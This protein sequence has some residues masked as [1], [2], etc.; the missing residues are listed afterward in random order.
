[1]E[2]VTINFEAGPAETYATGR[3]YISA[4]VH[5]QGRPQ[6]AIAADMDLSPS[7]L[8]RKLAQS[9]SDTWRLTADDREKFIEV[10]GDIRP[11]LYDIEKY[12]FN[13]ANPARNK[14]QLLKE[15]ERM[16]KRVEAMA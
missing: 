2:Q 12:I 3:E 13:K 7:G 5:Q 16:A 10:T 9:P 15:I 8:S 1:M 11:I 14:Q 6:K 4:L